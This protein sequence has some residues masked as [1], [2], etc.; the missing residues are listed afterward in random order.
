MVPKRSPVK[1]SDIIGQNDLNLEKANNVCMA[2]LN[3]A[4]KSTRRL[5]LKKPQ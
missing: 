2:S 3:R 1:N 4:H 5:K